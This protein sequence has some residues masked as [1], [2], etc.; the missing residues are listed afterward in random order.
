MSANMMHRLAAHSY[1]RQSAVEKTAG[2]PCS[3]LKYSVVT[4]GEQRNAASMSVFEFYYKVDHVRL[5]HGENGELAEI[6][7][8]FIQQVYNFKSYKYIYIFYTQPNASLHMLSS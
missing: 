6:N 5:H 8:L 1:F 7:Y 3:T 4:A 2:L